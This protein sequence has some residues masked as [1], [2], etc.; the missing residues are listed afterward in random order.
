[1]QFAKIKLNGVDRPVFAFAKW[2][3]SVFVVFGRNKKAPAD[4]QAVRFAIYDGQPIVWATD[5]H[6]LVMSVAAHVAKAAWVEEGAGRPIEFAPDAEQYVL[7]SSLKSLCQKARVSQTMLFTLDAPEVYVV[8]GIADLQ[9]T[10]EIEAT[11]LGEL[12][13]AGACSFGRTQLDQVRAALGAEHEHGAPTWSMSSR[14]ASLFAAVAKATDGGA[15]WCLNPPRGES[16]LCVQVAEDRDD[17]TWTI[18]VM[19]RH[20][21]AQ[22]A[23]GVKR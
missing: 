1:M 13:P 10:S 18:A 12:E 19:P 5:G 16:P 2:S 22:S 4:E 23:Q 15:A 9:T 11:L 20:A 8:D 17:S 14:F 21:A 3:A 7:A 6:A